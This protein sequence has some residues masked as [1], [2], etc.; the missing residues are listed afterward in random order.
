M[1]NLTGKEVQPEIRGTW[2]SGEQSRLL[3]L[4]V[5]FRT[6][7]VPAA[8]AAFVIA[9]GD[10]GTVVGGIALEVTQ[11]AADPTPKHRWD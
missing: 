7:E 5:T 10:A 11:W 9:D 8:D 4:P 3:S 1:I 2:L 6:L